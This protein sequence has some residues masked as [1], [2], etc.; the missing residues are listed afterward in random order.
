MFERCY[1]FELAARGRKVIAKCAASNGVESKIVILGRADCAFI[2]HIPLEYR[3]KSVVLIDIEGAEFELL[4]A[5]V[6]SALRGSIIVIE[7]HEWLFADGAQKL[8]RLRADAQKDF[9]VTELRTSARDL[10][11]FPELDA[12]SDDD[13][14]LLCS[15]GRSRSM[16]WYRL[17]PKAQDVGVAK[18]PECQS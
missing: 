17:D 14:W 16:R 2:E 13:R 15:E 4:T 10:S 6:F 18:P 5:G 9:I 1:C 8:Q 3:D 7:L 12:F 11:N